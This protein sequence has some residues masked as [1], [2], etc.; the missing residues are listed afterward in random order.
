MDL[1]LF[2]FLFS[3]FFVWREYTTLL[4]NT[5]TSSPTVKRPPTHS[6]SSRPR[7]PRPDTP[8]GDAS[9]VAR[10]AV[11]GSPVA[12]PARGCT[13]QDDEA[14]RRAL[15][16]PPPG[17]RGTKCRRVRKQIGDLTSPARRDF[18]GRKAGSLILEANGGGGEEEGG[19]PD[20]FCLAKGWGLDSL[21][22]RFFFW[23]SLST[24]AFLYANGVGIWGRDWNLITWVWSG[25]LI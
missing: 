18:G 10:A 2:L 13:R 19:L 17:S 22:L 15:P 16:A 7:L 11:L 3:F 1:F 25:T 20:F 14:A 5:P 21:S 12:R 8:H 24:I 6:L 4:L 23:F 9:S